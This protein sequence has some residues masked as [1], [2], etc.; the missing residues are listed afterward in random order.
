[1]ISHNKC[2]YYGHEACKFKD[3]VTMKKAIEYRLGRTHNLDIPTD[4]EI[5]AI[6]DACDNFTELQR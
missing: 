6:C 3:S 2:K 1:M 4:D 5:D